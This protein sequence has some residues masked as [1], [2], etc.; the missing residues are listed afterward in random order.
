[1]ALLQEL[2]DNP[3]DTLAME[4]RR[5]IDLAIFM[6][7]PQANEGILSNED[8]Y[9]D[10]RPLHEGGSQVWG[11]IAKA[12]ERAWEKADLDPS[13]L[14]C[15]ASGKE[16]HF[17]GFPGQFDDIALPADDPFEDNW[18]GPFQ[19]LGLDWPAFFAELPSDWDFST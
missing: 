14:Q 4:T 17:D 13:I 8:G 19:Q 18:L 6:C 16:I 10:T 12:R 3:F 7:G 2:E 5:L 11:F 9:S 1:M 15:P